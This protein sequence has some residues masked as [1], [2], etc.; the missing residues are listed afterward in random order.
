MEKAL[1]SAGRQITPASRRVK[2]ERMHQGGCES[3]LDYKII[4]T[5]N[6]ALG[7]KCL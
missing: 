1:G 4:F 7:Q 6:F 3:N 5:L 2:S